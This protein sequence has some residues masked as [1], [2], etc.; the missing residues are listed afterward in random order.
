ME[1]RP[2]CCSCA[3]G[4]QLALSSSVLTV[5]DLD[6]VDVTP[7]FAEVFRSV[8]SGVGGCTGGWRCC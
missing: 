4:A 3:R 8:L 5:L 1:Q 2:L 7:G 6:N